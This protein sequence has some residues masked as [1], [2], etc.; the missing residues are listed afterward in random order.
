MICDYCPAEGFVEFQ[1]QRDLTSL[2]FCGH[3][4]DEYVIPLMDKGFIVLRDERND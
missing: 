4:A 1:H 3:H 2:V